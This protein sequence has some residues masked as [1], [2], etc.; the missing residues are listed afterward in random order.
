MSL[1]RDS[2]NVRAYEGG[3]FR[4]R[5][6]GKGLFSPMPMNALLRIAKRY[7]YGA[8]KYGKS[9][10]FK[11]GL[12]VKDC[13]DSAMRHL[14]QYMNGDNSEDH[15]AAVCWNAMAMMYMEEEKPQWQDIPSRKKFTKGKGSFNYIE[16][17][18]EEGIK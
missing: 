18:I 2:E 3:S 6:P 15:L 1:D 9:E 8:L 12:P 10:A 16:K 17:A 4:D 13:F 14:I 5:P 11:D 7:E